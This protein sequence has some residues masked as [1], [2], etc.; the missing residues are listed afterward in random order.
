MNSKPYVERKSYIALT[1]AI[2]EQIGIK[3]P[4][5]DS[6]KRWLI[7]HDLEKD[8]EGFAKYVEMRASKHYKK[9]Y[10]SSLQ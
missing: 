8:P 5:P 3:P 9:H 10:L 6:L 2:C 1:I 4:T 7:N